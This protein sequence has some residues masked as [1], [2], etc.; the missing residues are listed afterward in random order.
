MSRLLS[1]IFTELQNQS[2]P[3]VSAS[4]DTWLETAAGRGSSGFGDRLPGMWVPG[5]ACF[6][7]GC[8]APPATHVLSENTPVLHTSHTDMRVCTHLL[9]HTV[10]M[11][12]C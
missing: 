5:Q 4:K 12:R 7:Q 8:K 10:P 9:T 6:P 3:G 1:K 11:M 2:V